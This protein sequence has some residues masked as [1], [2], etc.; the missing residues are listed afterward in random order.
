MTTP[1]RRMVKIRKDKQNLLTYCLALRHLND[2]GTSFTVGLCL[3][4]FTLSSHKRIFASTT[5]LQLSF[6]IPTVTCLGL[7]A[8]VP[9]KLT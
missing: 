8:S 6:N 2:L 5:S 9:T 4:R 3:N 7:S 1:T